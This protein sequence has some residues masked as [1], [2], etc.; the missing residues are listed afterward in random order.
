MERRLYRIEGRVQGVWFRESTR[1]EAQPRGITG[2]A[3]NLADGAVEVLC[4]GSPESLNAME[5]WL[6]KGP[7]L[8]RV[9]SVQRGEAPEGDLPRDFLTG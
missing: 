7:P 6:A 1:R 8:A 9:D 3:I 5:R 4:C 2:H